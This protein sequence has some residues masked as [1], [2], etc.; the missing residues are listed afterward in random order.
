[1]VEFVKD[2]IKHLSEKDLQRGFRKANKSPRR[3]FALELHEKGAIVQELLNFICNDSVIE[4][5]KHPQEGKIELFYVIQGAITV[6]IYDSKGKTKKE[7]LLSKG[8]M[9]IAMPNEYHN[10]KVH[11]LDALVYIM[12]IGKYNPKTHHVLLKQQLKQ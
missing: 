9:A 5:H 12:I 3:R 1:M 10:L 7:Y 2:K 11:S 6:Y 8:D 4:I